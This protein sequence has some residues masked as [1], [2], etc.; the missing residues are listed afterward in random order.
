MVCDSSDS[1][2]LGNRSAYRIHH[3]INC[4]FYFTHPMPSSDLLSDMY[5]QYSSNTMYTKKAQRKVTRVKRR[6]RRYMH[7]APGKRFLDAGCNIGSAVEAAFQ[8][9]FD[10]HGV[11]IG[12]D[13]IK[14]ARELHPDGNYHAGEVATMPAE[15]TAFD[16]VYCA[17]VI[18]HV[19]DPRALLEDLAPRISRGGVLYLD[20]PDAAHFRV[21]RN[22]LTWDMVCPPHHLVYFTKKSM[23]RLLDQ[24][25]FDV[26][27]FEWLHKPGLHTIARKR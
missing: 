19:P 15:W 12:R 24:T 1:S 22:F 16:F 21:P 13:G 11:D 2:H 20:T 6:I 14:I 25:G 4:D 9:G 26:I 10:A 3:C 17:D 5:N 18:E 23:T 8:L 27:K 7:Q